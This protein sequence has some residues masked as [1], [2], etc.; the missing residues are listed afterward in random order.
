MEGA[1]EVG[2]LDVGELVVFGD[3]S[4][5]DDDVD[6]EGCV[7][8]S[9]GRGGGVELGLGGGDEGGGP[10]GRAEVGLD[11]EGLDAVGGLEAVGERL[12]QGGGGGRGV[13][14][15]EVAAFRGEVLCYG[16]ADACEE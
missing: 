11:A 15:D 3:A 10:G 4:V 9:R 7:G 14:E 12:G 5:V 13:V 1:V 16:G 6:L 8:R 2:D